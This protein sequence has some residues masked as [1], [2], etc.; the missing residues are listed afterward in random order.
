MT[1]G[2]DQDSFKSIGKP[3]PRKEDER[4]LR[5]Q[6]QFSDDFNLDGQ[7]YAVM[8]RSF[9]PHAY[10]RDIDVS[11]ASE[12]PGVLLV[13]TGI[14][15][16][17][18][19]IGPIS[20][21]PVPSTRSDLKLTAPDGG[22]I[23]EGPH[24]LLSVD[25][26]RY[27]GEP[28]AMVIAETR[29]QATDAA[30]AVFVDYEPI[31]WVADSQDA[32]SK[33]APSVWD[34]V[35]DNIC[36]DTTFG[37]EKTTDAAFDKA[38]HIVRMQFNIGR[39]TG[40][41]LEPRAA[42]A[43]FNPASGRYTLYAGSNGAVRHKHQIAATLG[44][45]PENLRIL[46]FD[47]GGNFGTKNRV[48]SEFVL[49]LWA[50]KKLCRAVKYTATRAES[51]L[52]DYQGRDLKTS[53][54]LALSEDGQFLGYRASNLSNVGAWIVS[55]SPLGKGIAL[56]TGG[57]AI[58]TATAQARAVFTNTVPTQAYRSSGRPEV[59][60]SLE[61]LIDTAAYEYGFDPIELR[62]KNLIR[63]S[64]MPYTNPLG[65]TYDSG[66]YKK[67]MDIALELID[68][69]NFSDREMKACSRGKLLGRG[70]ANY[71]ESSIGA[72]G[73]RTDIT[74]RP[75]GIVEIVIGTQP[76]GQGQETSFAQ[77]AADF[78]GID[79]DLVKIIIGD[80]DV[81]KSGGGS[82]SGRSMRQAGTVIYLGC[83]DLVD[84]ARRIAAIILEVDSEEVEMLNGSFIVPRLAKT[85]GW[86]EI[87]KASRSL[88]LPD[89]LA[90]GLTVT[91][92]NE[93]DVAVFP[94]G[95][96]ACEVEV[97]PDTGVVTVERYVAVDDVGRVINPLIV[98]GQT[99]GSIATGLGQALFE[100][101][102]IDSDSGQPITGS[103]MDYTLPRA[104]DLPMFSTA[105][106]EVFSPTNPLG[107]KSGGEGPTTSALAVVINAIVNALRVYG[108]QDIEMPATPFRVWTAI[109]EAQ[110]L[111][112]E[113]S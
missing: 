88:D 96:A 3:I 42:L 45:N 26:V 9:Y 11:A 80:T 50:A 70:F 97:D 92:E 6:G 14:D 87:A 111:N 62:R 84:K 105:F 63:S 29:M 77:V 49:T 39:V 104:H 93:M 110:K 15:C 24:E 4:L 57:Y 21:N 74:V 5:G 106:N 13:L 107:I 17:E 73:E 89:D 90:N 69:S 61:R 32:T 75:E 37:D 43:D 18:E 22:K 66:D 58:P 54:E 100:Q 51:F 8:V 82:H 33:D 1:A 86:F 95:C 85:I 38:D 79:V 94:N 12:M 48:Y 72:P 101:C 65:I 55:L 108:V 53:V 27:V 109:R 102:V 25:K 34:N 2:F 64:A 67:S 20:H 10:I 98:D 19:G 59:C 41:P 76:T 60:H 35:P 36:V 103:L 112:R 30:E 28:I 113:N 78:M 40:V 52:S 56:V 47:V 83:Q 44:E 31:P 46:C 16:K 71:V 81:V 7:V 91:R 99:H 23:F 68:W